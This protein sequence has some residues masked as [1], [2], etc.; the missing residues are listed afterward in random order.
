[1]LIISLLGVA[2]FFILKDKKVKICKGY[3]YSNTTQLM[4][5]ESHIYRYLLIQ[6]SNISRDCSLFK[7]IGALNT[8]VIKLIKNYI[9]DILDQMVPDKGTSKNKEIRLPA[10]ISMIKRGNTLLSLPLKT[11]NK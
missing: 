8:D 4:L 3:L 9:W 10:G 6:I 2:G 11:N 5:L 7:L 1:M